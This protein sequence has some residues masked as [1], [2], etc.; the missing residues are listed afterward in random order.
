M[1][2][3]YSKTNTQLSS[4]FQEVPQERNRKGKRK[5]QPHL[6]KGSQL[7]KQRKF[8]NHVLRRRGHNIPHR[9]KEK[10]TEKVPLEKALEDLEIPKTNRE[11]LC[12]AAFVTA[13]NIS[14]HVAHKQKAEGK[15]PLRQCLRVLS[16]QQFPTF[17]PG[18]C[19]KQAIPLAIQHR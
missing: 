3:F 12:F 7:G 1:A 10:A 14:P 4:R 17:R 16:Q 5:I 9:K 15:D 8:W 13:Q 19:Q 18:R 2:T 11:T 6:W